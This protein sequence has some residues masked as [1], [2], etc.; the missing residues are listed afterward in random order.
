MT[1]DATLHALRA[2]NAALRQLVVIHDRL[3]GLVLQGAD[4]G[5][6]TVTLADLVGRRVLLLDA[7]LQPVAVSGVADQMAVEWRPDEGYTRAVLATLARERRPLRVPPMPDFGVSVSCVLAPVAVGDDI[8]GY[9]ALLADGDEHERERENLDLQIVQHASTVYALSMMRERMT[10]EVTRQLRDEL[11]EGVLLGR[12]QDEQVARER[13]VRLGYD[14]AVPYRALVLVVHDD[15]APTTEVAPER[16]AQRA[17]VLDALVEHGARC[18][19][20]ALATR[21]DDELIVLVPMAADAREVGRALRTHAL[22]LVPRWHVTLGIGGVAD[23]ARAI[24][25]SY[26]QARRALETAQR[27]GGQGDVVAFED[28]GVYRLLFHVSDP[29]ELG[30]FVEGALGGLLEYDR[31]HSSEL[32]E[33]LGTF[34]RFNGNVQATARALSLHVNSVTYRLQR[35]ASVSGLD[36]ENSEDRLQ[37]Q[38]ALKILNGIGG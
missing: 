34:L 27:F 5:A 33:T 26:A 23:S 13:A 17:R 12:A 37:A 24:A 25:R 2:Q 4:V 38:V 11:F 9:L 14:P 15:S 30:S 10:A 16:I 20:G 29:A 32:V 3:G 22:A 6:I 28:M 7:M 35:I 1:D 21:R 36:L 8:L 19:T 31:R 18:A